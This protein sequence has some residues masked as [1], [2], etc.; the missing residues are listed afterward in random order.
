MNEEQQPTIG[1]QLITYFKSVFIV[2]KINYSQSIENIKS[3]VE[4]K[5][6]NIWILICSILICSLGL[7]MNSTAVVIGAMLISPLMGPIVGLGLGIGTYDRNLIFKAL[8]NLGLATGISIVT[9]V[10]FFKITPTQ[11][12]SEIL[13]RTRP[14]VLDLFVAF[15]G[16]VAG[17]LAASRCI[18]TNVVPGVAIATALMPPL[19]TAGFG[20]AIGNWDYFAGASYLFFMNCIM[21][22]LAALV[23]TIYLRYPKFSFVNDQTKSRVKFA[24]VAVVLAI[25][26]PSVY[27]YYNL[28][29][30]NIQS[31]RIE[32]YVTNEIESRPGIFITNKVIKTDDSGTLIRLNINGT[33]LQEEEIASLDSQLVKYNLK[34]SRLQ[35]IQ[36]QPIG[37]QEQRL[38]S[39]KTDII[40]E[41]YH[42]SA[43][44]IE[45]KEQ[46]IAFLQEEVQKLSRANFLSEKVMKLAKTQYNID[47]IGVDIMV[48]SN[49]DML[50]TIPTAI[51]TWSSKLSNSEKRSQSNKL[52]ELI[53]IE[54]AVDNV[55][56]VGV[57]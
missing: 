39:L 46:E 1:R 49:G 55:K 26:L 23:V 7:N 44:S 16:G 30:E 40:T 12:V 54:L 35:I 31:K 48:Y 53:K 52:A 38:A 14:T 57:N 6:F 2:D 56:V 42:N 25:A 43:K 18:S 13:A 33:Y 28:L 50:D 11:E 20:L 47:E 22:S 37:F 51:V 24:I 15:F 9:A 45:S 29:Q 21:I 5:G 4:F 17:I 36:S 34:N 3:D 19:C 41:L 8:K 10:I 27:F 32:N